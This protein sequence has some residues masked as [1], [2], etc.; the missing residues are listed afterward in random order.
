MARIF[1]IGYDLT[2]GLEIFETM[3]YAGTGLTY[4]FLYPFNHKNHNQ[5]ASY[6]MAE[7]GYFST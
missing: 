4:L 3:A 6:K 5:S 1:M 2:A 7:F